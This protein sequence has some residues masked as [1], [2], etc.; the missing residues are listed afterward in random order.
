VH[1]YK[2]DELGGKVKQTETNQKNKPPK[3]KMRTGTK[4]LPED[5]SLG[6][7]TQRVRDYRDRVRFQKEAE[8]IAQQAL[9][10]QIKTLAP[11]DLSQEALQDAHDKTQRALKLV[12]DNAEGITKALVDRALEGDIQ[13]AQL[14]VNR[15]LPERRQILKFKMKPTADATAHGVLQQASAGEISVQD[16]QAALNL[17]E[18]VTDVSLSGALAERLR[19]L[20]ERVEAMKALGAVSVTGNHKTIDMESLDE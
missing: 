16:A 11:A 7:S 19:V 8:E 2:W 1:F 4:R 17:L 9:A 5:S 18:K 12:L 6:N 10:Y 3:V 14:L 13:A 20:T 15:F